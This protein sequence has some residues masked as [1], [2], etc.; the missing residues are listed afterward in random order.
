MSP[1][2]QDLASRLFLSVSWPD[3]AG[4]EWRLDGDG[5]KGLAVPMLPRVACCHGW[6]E[7][8]AVVLLYLPHPICPRPV[9]LPLLRLSYP[10]EGGEFW[11]RMV[12]MKLGLS[13]ENRCEES[14]GHLFRTSMTSKIEI[15]G[16]ALSLFVKSFLVIHVSQHPRY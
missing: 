13:M 8:I 10:F 12:M 6:D 2:V 15:H 1:V 16:L 14:E 9:S 3:E 5:K 7:S 11:G 4:G